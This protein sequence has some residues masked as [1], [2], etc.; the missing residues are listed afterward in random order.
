[1]SVNGKQGG[2]TQCDEVLLDGVMDNLDEI[3]YVLV[4]WML[5]TSELITSKHRL[6]TV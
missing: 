5:S 3:G 6:S 4:F 2:S 1:M